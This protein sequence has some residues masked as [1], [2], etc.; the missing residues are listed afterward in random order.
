MTPSGGGFTAS[1]PVTGLDDANHQLT[2]RVRDAAGNWSTHRAAPRLQVR[3]PLYYSTLGNTN[4]PGVSGTAD[5]SDIYSLERSGPQP[6]GRPVGRAVQ[7]ADR[8]ERRRLQPGQRHELL[9]FLRGRHDPPGLGCGG[10][11]RTWCCW[12]G[13]AWSVFFNGSSHGLTAA[14]LDLDAISVVGAT[15]YF[16]T[17]RQQ[18]PAGGGRRGRRRRHLQ[19]E[20]RHVVRAGLRRLGSTGSRQ[21]PTWTATT[22]WTRTHFYLSFAADT[23]V[24]GLGAVQDE[25][26]VYSSAGTWSVYFDGTAHGLTNANLDVDAFDVP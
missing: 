18:Q 23:T 9:P 7:R 15:L 26:V 21:R 5:D 2:V 8:G 16:S 20:R 4:P 1:M 12:N 10:R 24:T 22:G 19:L 13:S 14:N 17:R 11:T 3:A 6:V 25:D